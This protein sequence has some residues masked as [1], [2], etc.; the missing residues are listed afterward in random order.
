MQFAR[1]PTRN[2][3]RP[4]WQRAFRA[5]IAAAC[6]VFVHMA[7]A[8]EPESL[9][10]LLESA[11]AASSSGRAAD[12]HRLLAAR[13]DEFI[14]D[15]AF[16]YALG[17]AALED[18]RPD[19]ATL[20]F[21]RVLAVDP[22][23]AGAA[24]D[25]A[26][27]YLALG[28]REQAVATL[29]ALLALAPPPE[30]RARLEEM[31]AQAETGPAPRRFV[32]GH[33]SATIGRDSN[34]NLALAQSRVFVP[35]FG[36]E[37]DLAAS[38][39]AR[40]DRFASVGGSVEAQ[41]PLGGAWSMVGG[42]D[43]L[44]RRNAHEST[45]DIGAGGIRGG[46][47]ATVDGHTLRAQFLHARSYMDNRIL[48]K[49]DALVFDARPPE[50]RPLQWSAYVQMGGHRHPSPGL[51]SF[52][53]DFATVGVVAGVPVTSDL[54]A[55]AGASLGREADRGGN[56]GGDREIGGARAGVE[57]RLAERWSLVAQATRQATAY[58]RVDPAFTVV[59]RD[60]R[61]DYELALQVRLDPRWQLRAG[62]VTT[63]QRS[64]IAIYA[65]ERSEASLT[66]R[67]S[68]D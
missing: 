49:T 41:R 11:A 2:V 60:G 65:F 24:I 68:F 3:P 45:Y 29:R 10:K 40:A 16:D 15:P 27:A 63:R 48:R 38:N 23:H 57:A 54:V 12:A 66:A 36:V 59:R 43:L 34:V 61:W 64:S 22:S 1:S 46:L 44:V 18:G 30:T 42:G 14:G 8:A 33:L 37:V 47:A 25:M 62:L 19:R 67:W 6:V 7:L 13:E 56:P 20:A 53:A 4:A 21:S 52:D 58:E 28:N 31:L 51:R 55:F 9:R 32:R 39:L 26:R 35:V 50:E 17:R 5:G